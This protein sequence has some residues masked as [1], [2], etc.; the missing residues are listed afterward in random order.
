MVEREDGVSSR[1]MSQHY[2]PKLLR[3]EK[4]TCR[5]I[6]LSV[7]V[8][9]P[10]NKACSDLRMCRW[11]LEGPVRGSRSRFFIHLPAQGSKSIEVSA[12]GAAAVSFATTSDPCGC[13]I[14]RLATGREKSLS[15]ED[16]SPTA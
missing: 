10:K 15:T 5:V 14:G 13:R 6:H 11:C 3:C 7:N 2:H 12:A 1:G 16:L 8:F 4:S 9:F